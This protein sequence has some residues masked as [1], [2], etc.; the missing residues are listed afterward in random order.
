MKASG[1][2][3]RQDARGSPDPGAWNSGVRAPHTL[4][5]SALVFVF[6]LVISASLAP[7]DV[8]VG[9]VLSLL[10]GWWSARFL[11]AGQAPGISLRE[12]LAL[13]R[14]LARFSLQVLHSAIHVALIVMNP[15]LPIEP[16]LFVCRTQLQR[17]VSRIAF[18]HSV[19]LTPGTLTV[20]VSGSDFLVHCLDEE[21]VERILSGELERRVAEV[22]EQGEGA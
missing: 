2:P 1:R 13:L 11:W 20:D 22:F 14:Y 21:S 10:L 16:R 15:R 17:E 8:A 4:G 3:V 19:S 12:S 5:V 7:V 6:W 9:A 18:A